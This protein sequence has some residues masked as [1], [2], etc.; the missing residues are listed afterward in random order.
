MNPWTQD[1]RA[2]RPL[3]EEVRGQLT[4]VA[5]PKK[6][7]WWLRGAKGRVQ[8]VQGQGH[9][10][11]VERPA[12]SG[13]PGPSRVDRRSVAFRDAI[14]QDYPVEP[15]DRLSGGLERDFQKIFR[16][17][18][19]WRVTGNLGNNPSPGHDLGLRIEVK[20][21]KGPRD[22][23]GRPLEDRPVL[24]PGQWIEVRARQRR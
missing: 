10:P 3:A 2:R 17:Q 5:D 6:A 12:S 4:E 9:A 18:N 20:V 7:D 13:T 23:D 15:A 19:L 22:R 11:R 16:W 24:S 8:L 21:L 14:F 1:P